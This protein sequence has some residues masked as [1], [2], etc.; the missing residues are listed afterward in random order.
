[1]AGWWRRDPRFVLYMLREASALFVLG[2]ALWWLL[3]LWR[4][5]QGPEAFAQWLALLRHPV[6]LV[7]HGVG[8]G[9]VALHSVTWFQVMPKTLPPL[10]LS[11]RAV[12]AAGLGAAL[13]VSAALLAWLAWGAR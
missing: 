8:L 7:L 11:A 3:G 4:L 2:W 13:V 5:S 12:T 1:M 10:P 9:F 6:S